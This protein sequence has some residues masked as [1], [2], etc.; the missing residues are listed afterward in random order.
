MFKHTGSQMGGHTMTTKYFGVIGNR[1]YIKIDGEKRP[2]WEFL[3]AQPDGWLTS[4]TYKRKDLP[5]GKPMIFDCGAWS[6][7]LAEIPPIC[8][9]SAVD[10]YLEYAPEGSM[11]IAPDH[12]LIEG[13]D[14]EYR[15]RWNKEQ[16]EEFL[17]LCPPGYTPMAI[18]HGMDANER[19]AHAIELVA[20]GY[21]CLAV[22]GVAARAAQKAKVSAIV[23]AIRAVVPD[24]Y[25]HVLGLTSPPYMKIWDEYGVDSA[26]GSSHFK[27]AFTGG[28]FFT[29]ND[30]LLKHKASRPGE[31]VTAPLCDC[32]ACTKLIDQG[33]DT[34]TYG[35]NENNMGRAAHNLNKLMEAH[36][37]IRSTS[38]LV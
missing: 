16:A 24:V 28:A 21:Q 20:M 27:Q 32:R 23:S 36:A 37:W 15:T 3:D 18:I 12:M 30:G 14:I 17:K 2:F 22:G 31:D 33:I 10:K 34:R 4:L 1:D 6:Y 8:A 7:K 19:V 29:F 25:L 5:T 38:S 35:S 13:C 11:L 9:A 26:D